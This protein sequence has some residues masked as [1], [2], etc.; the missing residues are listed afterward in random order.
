MLRA[1]DLL[2]PIL[3][4]KI[5]II[6]TNTLQELFSLCEEAAATVLG[7]E[8]WSFL[9]RDELLLERTVPWIWDLARGVHFQH[10]LGTAVPLTRDL[11]SQLSSKPLDEALRFIIADRVDMA[12]ILTED[13]VA[14]YVQGRGAIRLNAVRRERSFPWYPR[15]QLGYRIRL[16]TEALRLMSAVEP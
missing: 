4:A 16:T 3:I 14:E 1:G 15:L 10:F 11:L 7:A 8:T 2:D 9:S 6:D 13:R 5:G 12:F